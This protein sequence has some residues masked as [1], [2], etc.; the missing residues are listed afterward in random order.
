[1]KSGPDIYL[2]LS[3]HS[4]PILPSF[5]LFLQ[6]VMNVLQGSPDVLRA[7]GEEL[8]LADRL[9]ICLL[10]VGWTSGWY[11]GGCIWIGVRGESKGARGKVDGSLRGF[12]RV[13]S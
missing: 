7:V 8:S 6:N 10:H 1:M 5:L 9:T 2:S 4:E 12:Q 11:E 13:R 3:Y